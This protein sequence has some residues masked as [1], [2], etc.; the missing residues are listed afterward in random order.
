VTA[1]VGFYGKLPSRGDFLR[2]GLPRSFVDPWDDWWQSAIT[3]SLAALGEAWVP[4][5]M[6]A[7]VWRFAIPAGQCGPG[8]VLG[9]WMPSVDRA[10]RHFPL[11]LARMIAGGDAGAEA[12]WLDQA[13]ADGLAA[14][15]H[16]TP[17]ET[18]AGQLLAAPVW[19]APEPDLSPLGSGQAVWWTLGAPR[20]APTVLVLGG[21][22][23][24]A[25]FT[26]MLRDGEAVQ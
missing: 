1:Q 16:D 26:A 11:T 2:H 12:G 20:V 17:P 13:E 4:A 7:P 24:A 23:D 10:G 25:A 9:L 14:L 22:P 15:E 19:P 5:W 18:L 8:A 21:L 3:G 6:E